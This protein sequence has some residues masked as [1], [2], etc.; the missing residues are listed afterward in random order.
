MAD[1][2]HAMVTWSPRSTF[3]PDAPRGITLWAEILDSFERQRDQCHCWWGKVSVG[4]DLG[5]TQDDI[6]LLNRQIEQEKMAGGRETH[7]YIYSA[8]PKLGA[9][10]LHVGLLVEVRGEDDRLRKDPHAPRFFERVEYRIPFW[11][12]V[13][14]IRSIPPKRIDDLSIYSTDKP[15]DPNTKIPMPVL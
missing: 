1:L 4:G 6:Q 13:T 5:M 2:I 10:S 3:D 15:F 7:L 14:D 11:F 12:K 9:P 8:D